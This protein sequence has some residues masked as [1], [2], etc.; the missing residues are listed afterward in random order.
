MV[1]SQESSTKKDNLLKDGKKEKTSTGHRARVKEKFNKQDISTFSNLELIE[2]LLFFCN[3]RRDVKPEAKELNKISGG[4]MLKFLFLTEEEIKS[5]DIKYI[6]DNLLFLNKIILELT[7]RFFKDKI[8]EFTFKNLDDIKNYLITRS[9]F[10]SKEELRVLY[11][12]SKNK[13]IDDSVVSRGTINETAIYIREV[14]SLALKKTAMSIIISHNHPSGDISPSREDI[15]V[16]YDLKQALESVSIK[17][18][19]HIITSGTCYF[20]FKKEGLL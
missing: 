19:D 16:T 9:G 10:L 17:L 3:A 2:A 1:Y 14:V 8:T 13:L 12:N 20:S 6:G 18:Q 7:A 15:K 5:N 11:L 4:N